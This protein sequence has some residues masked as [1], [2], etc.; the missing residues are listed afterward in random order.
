MVVSRFA[1][2]LG[3]ACAAAAPSRAQTVAAPPRIVTQTPVA[4]PAPVPTVLKPDPLLDAMAPLPEGGVAWPAPVAVT[5]GDITVTANVGDVRYDVTVTGLTEAAMLVR[6][7]ELSSLWKGRGEGANLAQINRRSVEDADLIDQLLRA[8]GRYGGH[9]EVTITPPQQGQTRTQVGLA[10]DPGPV[11][12]FAAIDLQTPSPE[13][14]KLAATA[15]GLKV[16]EPVDAARV[17]NAEDGLKLRLADAGYPFPTVGAQDVVVDHA[18]RSATLTQA[19][20]P[21]RRASFGSVRFSQAARKPAFDDEHLALLA[22]LKPGDQ[23]NAADLEDLR[24]A[25]IQTGLFGSVAIRPLANGVAADGTTMVDLMVT[26]EPAP[27]RTVSAQLGYSTGQGIRLE[28]SWQHRNLLPPEGG[29]TFRGVA[30]EREQLVGAELRRHNW[31]RRDQ[32]LLLTSQVSA[33]R[34]DAY[35]ARSV[36]LGAAVERETNIIWQKKWTYSLGT[37]LVVTSQKDRSS[38]ST[39]YDTYLIAA[40]PLS[41]TYDG[42]DSLLDPARGFRLTGRLSPEISYQSNIFG[43]V[44]AQIDASVYQPVTSRLVLAAR[45]HV[46]SILGASRGTIAPTRRFYAGGGGSVRG[47]G[48]QQVGPMDA[49]DNPLGGNSIVE[50]SFEA[51]YRFTA[52]GNELGVVPF[53]DMGQVSTTTLPTFTG[54]KVG[55]GLG[56]RY[57]TSFGPVRIDV[58]TPVNPGPNDPRVAFYVSIGQAF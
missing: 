13:A 20:D 49:E 18:T 55:A 28:G 4:E 37:E 33:E 1:A 39:A 40:L 41:L 22:R 50:A 23:Y 48:Y 43:Y 47:F 34:Q 31:R 42:S 58:A 36:T 19:I 16:G 12:T 56:L 7:H 45:G 46:G 53:I 51:R 11:Y 27:L 25:L 10:V 15:L 32:T 38:T 6:F 3:V 54:L 44:K 30:S 26:T 2:V 35:D 21:G 24:R 8:E 52:F 14:A 57:Y 29:V 9:V 17:G 5:A